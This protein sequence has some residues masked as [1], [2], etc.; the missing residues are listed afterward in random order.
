M[1]YLVVLIPTAL[2]MGAVGLLAFFWSLRSGQYDDLDGAAERVLLNDEDEM[3]LTDPGRQERAEQPA[4]GG[5][6]G[7]KTMVS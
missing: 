5:V 3:P 2:A 6:S 4:G 1:N 7:D